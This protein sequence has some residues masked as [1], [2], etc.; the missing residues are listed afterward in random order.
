MPNCSDDREAERAYTSIVEVLV[1]ESE[2]HT[3]LAEVRE[4]QNR[5]AEAIDQWR[6]VAKLRA[7]EPTGLLRLAAAQ[8]HEK[9]W[10]AAEETVGQLCAKTWPPRFGNTQFQ[11]QELQRQ[12]SQG[13]QAR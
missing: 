2:S 12:I 3:M 6:Q 4:G 9:Q 5:W 10:A 8:V 7:L 1:S 13:N 11:I